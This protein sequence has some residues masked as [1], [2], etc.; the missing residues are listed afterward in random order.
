MSTYSPSM[1]AFP[2]SRA[3]LSPSG[4]CRIAQ[5]RSKTTANPTGC[6]YIQLRSP[7]V[8]SARAYL[9]KCGKI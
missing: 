2:N 4:C 5:L 7:S 8:F 3:S 1:S 6:T 9:A